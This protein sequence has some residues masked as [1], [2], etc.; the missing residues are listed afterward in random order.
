[1]KESYSAPMKIQHLLLKVCQEPNSPFPNQRTHLFD[2]YVP[3]ILSS[4]EQP[5]RTV[6]VVQYGCNIHVK[7]VDKIFG[8]ICGLCGCLAVFTIKY[9][10]WKVSITCKALQQP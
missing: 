4:D 5:V 7:Y 6:I 8:F 10:V 1:M 2:E 9:N 3:S